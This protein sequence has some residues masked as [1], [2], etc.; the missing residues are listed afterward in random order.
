MKGLEL[1]RKYYIAYGKEMLEK[2]FPMLM[3]RVAV[4]LVGQGS[5]CLGFDD[6][7]SGD[8]DYGPSFCLWLTK[9]DYE[10]YGQAMMEEYRKLP[11][12]FE[13][14][15]GR[16]ESFH[17]SG[18]VGVLCIPDFY[19]GILGMEDIPRNNKEWMKLEEAAL[20]TA[21]N[22]E[23]FE[24]PM[25]EFS[26]IRSGLLSYY[27]EDV[28]IKKIA[29]RAAVMAQSG[30]YNYARA[31]KR[32]EKVAARLALAEFMK[33][34][35]S[36][37]YLLNRR[38]TPFYKWMR[39]GMKELSILSEIGD[40]LDLL[41][42]MEDQSSVWEG[43]GET[44]YLYTINGNDKCVIIVEAVCNLVVQELAAQGLTEGEDNFLENHTMALMERIKDPYIRS[45][46]VMEG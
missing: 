5:E 43:V 31:M 41:A 8:H 3:G 37:V 26:R 40:I 11:K 23:V 27:P 19:Y 45:L 9:E 28:R 25:G 30:Q 36:M 14:V 24:D 35:I 16:T 12:D 32:G 38:Y 18:R 4:G 15:K 7:I 46:H 17:G 22:G 33:S 13:G 39:H 29:A 44:D 20:C 6:E 42:G 2:K 34:A 21:T 10:Q 1:S